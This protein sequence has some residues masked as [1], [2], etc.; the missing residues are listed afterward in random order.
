MQAYQNHEIYTLNRGSHHEMEKYGVKDPILSMIQKEYTCDRHDLEKLSNIS[1]HFDAIIDCCGYQK[2]DIQLITHFIDT[3]KYL[4]VSTVDVYQKYQNPCFLKKEDTPFQKDT[5]IYPDDLKNYIDGKIALEQ[6]LV[7]ECEKKNIDYISIRPSLIYGPYNYVPRESLY[8]Q[9]LMQTGQII[10]PK[11][12]KGK[13]QFV[14]V[15]DVCDAM[16]KLCQAQTNSHAYNLCSNDILDYSKFTKLFL[17]T[18][19]CPY[20]DYYF[21]EDFFLEHPEFLPFPYHEWETELCDGSK[22]TEDIDFSYTPHAVGIQKT[23]RAF[24]NVY[25]R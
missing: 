5:S 21:E 11:E 6:E 23:Y 1:V 18:V 16:L 25:R 7:E 22:I 9:M 20:Q 15:K 14:Y 19:D 3:T 4:F 13:F 8:V 2:G 12:A 24:Q 17:S 10:F